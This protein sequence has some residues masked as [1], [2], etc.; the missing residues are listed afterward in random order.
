MNQHLKGQIWL[1]SKENRKYSVYITNYPI[2]PL[3]EL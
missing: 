2:F 1:N 3:L